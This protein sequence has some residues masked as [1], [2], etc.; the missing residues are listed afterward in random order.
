ML[1]KVGQFFVVAIISAN[2]RGAK[3]AKK[4]VNL[5]VLQ[6]FERISKDLWQNSKYIATS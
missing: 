3:T 5:L 6:R 1:E 4:R 2:E